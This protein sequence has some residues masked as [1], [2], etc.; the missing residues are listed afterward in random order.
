MS[1]KDAAISGEQRRINPLKPAPAQAESGEYAALLV[2][3]LGG[4]DGKLR[5]HTQVPKAVCVGCGGAK[6]SF[7]SVL[8]EL[9]ITPKGVL[10]VTYE[11]G[12]REMWTATYKWRHDA[13]A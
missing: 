4:P 11:G 13:K 6:G 1:C 5:L 9:S 3:F 10:V 12:S 8:G 2:V 7:D